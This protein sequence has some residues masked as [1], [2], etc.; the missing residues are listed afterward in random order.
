MAG[1]RVLLVLDNAA[2]TAQVAPLLPGGEAC[3]VL[4][5]SRRHLADLPGVVVPMLVEAMPPDQA[6]TMFVRLAPRAAEPAAREL[7]R[8]A[9]NLPLAIS[10][11][12]R[13]Y[14]R[15]RSWTLTDLIR[16]TKASLLTLTAEKDTVAAAFEVSYR[17]M[18]TGRQQFF[19]R[20]SL[21]PGT[22]VDAYAAAALADVSL[23][24]AGIHLD[25]LHGECLLTEPSYR[26]YGMHDLIRRYARDRAAVGHSTDREGSLRRLLA[27][28][29][30]A[31][32]VADI[33]LAR[34]TR[35]TTALHGV[36]SPPIAVPDLPH[37]TRALS[38]VRTERATLFA[39]LEHA[40]RTG[41]HARVV[42]LT[43]A[44][45][46]L[47][48]EDG[49]WTDAIARH[50]T[51]A[52]AARHRGD[53]QGEASALNELGD[54]LFLSGDFRPATEVQEKAL[55]I[56]RDLGDQQGQA[57]ALSDLG[58]LRELTGDRRGTADLKEALSICRALGD[59]RGEAWALDWTGY[60]RR[61]TG[62]LAGATGPLAETLRI[63]RDLDFGAGQAC[64]SP[65][66]G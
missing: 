59:R 62:D 35:A 51:S 63:Y 29:Q 64:A 50:T 37:Y 32:A 49:P 60:A 52:Q 61:L 4:V 10:L 26:R 6:Q 27:Y 54:A 5:T 65:G 43:V 57:N 3:L 46:A 12:A 34:I 22:T 7:V 23:R 8:L 24:E 41:Q 39:C 1:Q 42:G 9:G 18:P 36:T 33:H 38:W 58:G 15:H 48:R 21:H 53:R 40:T 44:V 14:A 13:V 31:A 30:H 45:A 17:Y 55:S 25:A 28:Y 20:L 2:G 66:P 11:L 19:R 47:L 56:Y 16:E